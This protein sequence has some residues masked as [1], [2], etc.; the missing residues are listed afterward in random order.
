V[1]SLAIDRT[2]G[3]SSDVRRADA[4]KSIALDFGIGV[5]P[6]AIS[7]GVRHACAITAGPGKVKGD[8]YCW[9]DN[10]FGQSG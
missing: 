4:S 1:P 3:I 6:V 5:I 7:L 8:L 9:G 2:Q 10:Y